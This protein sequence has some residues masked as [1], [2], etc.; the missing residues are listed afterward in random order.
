MK[1]E[2]KPE[3]TQPLQEELKPRQLDVMECARLIGSF[4]GGL[5]LIAPLENVREALRH[6]KQ[7][8]TPTDQEHRL[9]IRGLTLHSLNPEAS[10][11][12]GDITPRQTLCLVLGFCASM[13]SCALTSDILQ[14]VEMW[15]DMKSLPGWAAFDEVRKI[16]R[17]EIK[18]CQLCG[19]QGHSSDVCPNVKV[20][21]SLITEH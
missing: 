3:T 16:A 10:R 1:D 20:N 13:A 4:L 18:I 6:I 19:H 21:R 17:G 7:N 15:L 2:Q 8:L 9:G 5:C 11:T 14:G 12:K